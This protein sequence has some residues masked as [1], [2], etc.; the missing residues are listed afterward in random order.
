MVPRIPWFCLIDL[1]N[2]RAYDKQVV[3]T[4]FGEMDY[5]QVSGFING[6]LF[7]WGVYGAD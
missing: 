5:E 3:I 2:S 4:S 1:F 6:V 7:E